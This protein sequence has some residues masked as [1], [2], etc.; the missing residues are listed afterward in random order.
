MTASG[1]KIRGRE[2]AMNDKSIF[3]T[4]ASFG[5][6]VETEDAPGEEKAFSVYKGVNQIFT[7]PESDVEAF[8][9]DYEKTRPPLMQM[10]MY[11]YK[12]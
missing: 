2:T 3:D 4:A 11:G 1:K 8:L 6:T 7:D 12:E 10:S 5:L 9:T